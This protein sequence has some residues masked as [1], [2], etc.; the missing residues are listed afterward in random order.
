MEPTIF[1]EHYRVCADD[2]GSPEDV[3]RVCASN[4][5]KAIDT[6]SNKP[7]IVQR[8]A[9]ADLEAA[10]RNEIEERAHAAE[11]LDHVNIAKTLLCAVEDGNLVVISEYLEGERADSW[12]AAHGPMPTDAV[13]RAGLQVVRAVAAADFFKLAHRAIQP[14]NLLIVPG[15]SPDGGWPFVKLL[16]FA[17][18]GFDLQ[19]RNLEARRATSA[20]SA[21]STAD[22]QSDGIDF[23]SEMFSLGTTMCFLLT[24]IVPSAVGET[25]ARFRVRGVPELRRAP[26]PLRNLL[27]HMLSENPKKR[28]HDPVAFEREMRDC[29]TKIERRQAIGRRFG[30]PLATIVPTKPKKQKEPISPIAQVF[31]GIAAFVVLFVAAAAAAEFFFP[32][33]ISSLYRTLASGVGAGASDAATATPPRAENRSG[34]VAVIPS[35]PKS[36]TAIVDSNRPAPSPSATSAA[37]ASSTSAAISNDQAVEPPAPGA[38]PRE[39]AS[40]TKSS[41]GESG[42]SNETIGRNTRK[43]VTSDSNPTTETRSRPKPTLRYNDESERSPRYVEHARPRVI[44]RT[45]GGRRILEL[46]SGRVV[47]ERYPFEYETGYRTQPRRRVYMDEP[48]LYAPP[49]S[50]RFYPGYPSN[51]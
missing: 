37:I 5:C 2:H 48:G 13:L 42:N 47:I 40:S 39:S 38:G 8:I 49:P 16:N 36:S 24:G 9:I 11:K 27:A 33:K 1:L 28:P 14:A 35:P 22:E 44:G 25:G 20:Y 30:I 32:D 21:P 45:P 46:P 12:V 19:A 23:G 17:L 10:K 50:A 29:L 51:D 15:Q 7:V 3:D 18:A 34:S 26:K 4:G 6:R 41:D 31:G 43:T